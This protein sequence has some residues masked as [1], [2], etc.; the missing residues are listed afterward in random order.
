MTRVKIAVCKWYGDSDRDEFYTLAIPIPD[1]TVKLHVVT[2]FRTM[3]AR[4]PKITAWVDWWNR[5]SVL[6]LLSVAFSDK[7]LLEWLRDETN[8]ACESHN[9]PLAKLRF[10]GPQELFT[11]TYRIDFGY[12]VKIA[13]PGSLSEYAPYL[14]EYSEKRH[15][16][17]HRTPITPSSEKRELP[18]TA[19]LWRSNFE[20]PNTWDKG[21]ERFMG[22]TITN[23]SCGRASGNKV[24][25]RAI[26][27]GKN[28]WR[29]AVVIEL[30]FDAVEV[31]W[32]THLH[33]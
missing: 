1:A 17:N 6:E 16:V 24:C 25:V 23:V 19:D 4:W 28:G 3:K 7:C 13:E 8:N 5:D 29:Y 33:L 15:K 26:A 22:D 9:R 21:A 31:L 20:Y 30:D 2:T 18:E 32:H 27:G 14:V 11:E 12:A 10:A